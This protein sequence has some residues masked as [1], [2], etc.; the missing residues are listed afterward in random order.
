MRRINDLLRDELSELVRSELKDP[1]LDTLISITE[2]ETSVDL[3]HARVFVSVFGTDEERALAMR[4]LSSAAPFLRREL[5]SRV[6]MRHIPD[7]TF[8]YDDR[9]EEGA[10]ML[11]ILDEVRT[12]TAGGSSTADGDEHRDPAEDGGQAPLQRG[13]A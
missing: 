7:L 11:R 4:A 8:R 5:S 1:R 2:V 13:T 12:S 10:R 6:H 3:R 9:I